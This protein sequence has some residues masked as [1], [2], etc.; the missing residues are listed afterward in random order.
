MITFSIIS[1]TEMRNPTMQMETMNCIV[2]H[3]QKVIIR[4]KEMISISNDLL[5]IVVLQ[6]RE[7]DGEMS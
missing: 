6:I 4:D 3:T 5:V 7:G 1:D 2:T